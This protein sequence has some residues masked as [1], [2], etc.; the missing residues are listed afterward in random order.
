[1]QAKRIAR[2]TSMA[3][4]FPTLLDLF[5][6]DVPRLTHGRSLLPD[7]VAGQELPALPIFIDQARNPYYQARHAF[8][9]NGWKLH[10]SPDTGQYR[11]FNITDGI[12]S[13]KSLAGTEPAKFAEM[14]AAYELFMSRELR[15]VS[16]VQYS[17]PDLAQMPA[18]KEGKP[19]E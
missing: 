17:G 2:P 1:M 15:P 5:G 9:S 18:P 7:W 11:L 6:V 19:A 12:D 8:L 3:D 10:H 16:P 14:K 13:G 4:M